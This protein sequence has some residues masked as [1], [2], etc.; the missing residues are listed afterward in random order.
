MG[1]CKGRDLGSVGKQ[2]HATGMVAKQTRRSLPKWK[3]CPQV[4]GQIDTMNTFVHRTNG[5]V[6]RLQLFSFTY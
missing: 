1:T 6:S 3:F 5:R 2:R 4:R